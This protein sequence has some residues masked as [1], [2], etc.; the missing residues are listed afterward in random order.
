MLQAERKNITIFNDAYE[1]NDAKN[2]NQLTSK[3]LCFS[4][5]NYYFMMTMM[6]MMIMMI[7]I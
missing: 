4:I 3:E 2:V 5:K 6:I 1:A 7:I